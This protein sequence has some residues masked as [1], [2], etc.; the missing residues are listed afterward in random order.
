MLRSNIIAD[1]L[2][3]EFPFSKIKLFVFTLRNLKFYCYAAVASQQ[4]TAFESLIA[5][6]NVVKIEML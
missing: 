3:P 2:R 5:I 1:A 4:S 6:E